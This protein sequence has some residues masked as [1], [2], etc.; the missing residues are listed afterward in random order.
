MTRSTKTIIVSIEVCFF[1]G[2]VISNQIRTKS[3][4][5]H[6]AW[7]NCLGLLEAGKE[8]W[9]LEHNGTNGEVVTWDDLSQYI[10]PGVGVIT[11]C[12]DGGIYR[13]GK[14]GEKPTWSIGGAVHTLPDYPK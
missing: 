4:K 11:N 13:I 1:A 14:V 10:W 8:Q 9:V 2:W 12:R 3:N 5:A 7:E 6:Y